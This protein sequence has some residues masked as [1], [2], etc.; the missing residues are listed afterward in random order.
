M[1]HEHASIQ[2]CSFLSAILGYKLIKN[3]FE[4]TSV[5]L[6]LKYQLQCFLCWL[7]LPKRVQTPY[8]NQVHPLTMSKNVLYTRG[9]FPVHHGSQVT[10]NSC[11]LSKHRKYMS[12]LAILASFHTS[13]A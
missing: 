8:K 3:F 5:V 10:C 9:N 1:L 7:L 11:I 4:I 6:L 13:L 12:D 2:I